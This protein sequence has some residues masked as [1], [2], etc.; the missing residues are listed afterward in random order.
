M[1]PTQRNPSSARHPGMNAALGLIPVALSLIGN[2]DA[3]PRPLAAR[4]AVASAARTGPS[5]AVK[6][7]SVGLATL[8]SWAK[9][10][11]VS[12]KN[13]QV[14][15]RS[16]VHPLASDCEIHFGAHTPDFK[17]A[18]DGLV[19]EPMN[20]CVAPFPGK[21][22]QSNRDYTEFG[23]RLISGGPVTVSGVG[24]LWPEHLDGGTAS[25]PDHAA[26]IHPVAN[27]V[28]GNQTFDFA[29]NIFAGEYRGGV[30]EPTAFAILRGTS[31]SVE[32]NGSSVNINFR[33]GRIGNF[34]VLTINIDPS[35]I[36]DDGAG[37]FRMR[38]TVDVE[39]E[40][41]AVSVVSVA[42]SPIND[43][44]PAIKS[45]SESS[46]MDALVLFSLDPVA[47]AAA[48]K[49]SR[50]GSSVEVDTP[51]QLILYGIAE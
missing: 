51:I 28:F 44:M 42:G 40:E 31:V 38:A 33:G 5:G 47:L 35:S 11:V 50:A 24:R 37:S 27:I 22:E 20:A 8:Q 29:P 30:G 41:V 46:S 48:A 43:K 10:I 32:K 16:N 2:H 4:S 15:G 17:G 26:E 12:V 1:P 14:E 6:K 23:D 45:G 9:T 34:T 7:F 18:P 39:G 21:D 19:L 3:V 13:V 49:R 36:T 25:N